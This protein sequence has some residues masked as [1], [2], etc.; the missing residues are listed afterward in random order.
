MP[1][2][3]TV[4]CPTCG[5]TSDRVPAELRGRV[6][7]CTKCAARFK[8]TPTEPLPTVPEAEVVV[9]T[10]PE[11]ALRR[12]LAAA[13]PEWRPGELILGLYEVLGVLGQGGM[14]RV[15]RVRHRGWNLDLA[16]KVP[17][18]AALEAAGG[19]DHFEREAEAW[20]QLG[21]HPQ[22]VACHYVRRFEGL[23]L[24]FAEYADGGSLHEAIRGGRL[25]SVEA[26]LDVAVQF[27]WGLHHAHEQGLVHR[28]VK[29]ANV[30][31][32]SD[33]LAKVTDF[34]LAR[35]RSAAVTAQTTGEVAG[36]ITV[37]GGGGATPAYLSPEQ[38]RGDAMTRRSDAWSF[39][40]SVL[41]MFLG[42]RTW[43]LGLAVPETLAAYRADA[44]AAGAGPG[45]PAMPEAVADLLARCLRENAD[46]RPH[47][48]AAIAG[49]LC[50]AWQAATG[51]PYPRRRPSGG[52]GSADALNNRAASLVDLGREADADAL[53][54]Q[55]LAAEP[56]HP[57]ATYNSALR[58]WSGARLSDPEL[59]RQVEA[60]SPR[61][62]S[63]AHPPQLLGRLQA[64]L[65]HGAEDVADGCPPGRTLRGLAGTVAALA[66]GRDGALVVAGSGAEL[67]AW[68]AADG[69]LVAAVA[70]PDGP[71]RAVAP[72]PD[73]RS[74]VVAGERGPLAAWDLVSGRPR[75]TFARQ[76]GF[77]ASLALLPGG[78]VLSGGSDRAVRVWDQKTG[79][80]VLE[81]P[82][83][84]DAVT[85]VA[86]GAGVL[87]SASRDGTVRLWSPEDGRC[88]AVLST[89]GRLLALA[90]SERTDLLAAAGEDG[91]IRLWSLGSRQARLS[92][93][94]HAQPVHALL[95]SPDGGRLVSGSADSTVRIFDAATGH[96]LSLWR[97]EAAVHSLAWGPAGTLW[98]AH[99]ATVTGAVPP[100]L[101]L[102]PLALCRPAS[103][104]DEE[105]RAAS[106][107]AQ[108]V[109][110]RRSL[111]S[112]DVAAALRLVRGARS[113][114]GRAR[115][116]PAMA[117]W[118]DLCARLPRRALL[119]AWEEGRLEGHRDAVLAV[120]VDPAAARVAT[121]SLDGAARVFDLAT[122]RLQHAL[123]GHA[124]AVT[125]VAFAAGGA[126]LLSGSRDRT[127][128]LWDTTSGEPLATLE[129][130]A[131][132][133]SDLDVACDGRLAASA[134]WDGAVRLWD[135]E[136]QAPLQVLSGHAANV[137]AVRF[138]A[139]GHVVASA[140]WDGTVRLWDAGDG[141]PLATFQGPED[142]TALAW[143][144]RSRQ[145]AVAG[146][147][148]A[149]RLLEPRSGRMLRVLQGHEAAVTGLAFT[150]DGRFLA[151]ASRD[152]TVRTWDLR[153]HDTPRPL[154][155]PDAVLGVCLAASGTLL[156]SAGGDRLARVWHL[157]WDPEPEA[158]TAVT[159]APSLAPTLRAAPPAASL[160]P[161][162]L[163]EDLQRTAAIAPVAIPRAATRAAGRAAR[164][165]PWKWVTLA[166]LVL[167]AALVSYQ[168]SWHRRPPQLRL[169][170][171]AS[172]LRGDG[173]LIDVAAF[174]RG[175]PA[176]EYDRHLQALRSGNPDAH[177]VACL[178]ARGTPDVISDVLDW[179][180]LS[181][182]DGLVTRRLRRNAASVLAGLPAAT[183]PAL[184]ARLGD[185]REEVRATT[186]LAV[187]QLTTAGANECIAT[188]IA[189][190]GGP[191]KVAAAQALQRRLARGLVEPARGWAAAGAL[192][193]DAEPLARRAGVDLLPLFTPGLAEPAVR[194]LLA[195]P[196]PEVAAEARAALT[197]I[198]GARRA[199]QLAGD[200][201]S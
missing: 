44:G 143:H 25:A 129:G 23:P 10:V 34:G 33:G 37:E 193:Q 179:A 56:L 161:L 154:A 107:D 76:P 165:V 172:N 171:L 51:M 31:L 168:F 118:D 188:Q 186:A 63:A 140:G 178:A 157:D 71:L 72:L 91:V 113:I 159:T 117:V 89:P 191:A 84:T 49:E 134:G 100:P 189:A 108:V 29:P 127:L 152:R 136:R 42:R 122:R 93:R 167:A 201:G 105:S 115:A 92:L 12:T 28:D 144:P 150:P 147:D 138:S 176:D 52:V 158:L 121:A 95:L 190:G 67:R 163:R 11:E 182:E 102:P 80:P 57:E 124:A 111:Q 53:W 38:A 58:A 94:A 41:E 160:R 86:G 196:D 98:A 24:V 45:R 195:D 22:V 54:Q 85:A 200:D 175:C 151:S 13:A 66:S 55:A 78:R 62:A 60:A 18:A 185:G 75:R 43:T 142:P 101:T 123:H 194:P 177:D 97:V 184:C 96:V 145:L 36:T 35:A 82:G 141:R 166:A 73:G 125:A 130:H 103:A 187:G 155:H 69:A 137:A 106:F 183:L 26:I 133:V 149:V 65:G 83:H 46:E 114:P 27:A 180:P 174:S 135:L 128:R 198:Q 132:T 169:S 120:A 164:R 61:T 16:L 2:F 110:A 68:S 131:E 90:L 81:L 14:G 59:V 8:V 9:P 146:Q 104:S 199:D 79:R 116:G 15:Y 197:A 70:V 109:E 32:T 1:S 112:G 64:L 6:V 153:G 30:M 181:G 3:L 156:L 48:L 50:D 139:D 119:S 20:V 74:V 87:A 88:L 148:G 21:L 7:R 19:A 126:R 5:T 192:L 17:L 170:S 47:D 77:A 40:V 162:P 4:A 99:G 39:A 173:E